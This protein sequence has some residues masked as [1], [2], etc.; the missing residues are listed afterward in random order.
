MRERLT[1]LHTAVLRHPRLVVSLVVLIA[2]LA[3]T[4]S[5]AALDGGAVESLSLGNETNVEPNAINGG[6][7]NP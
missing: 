7:T 6:P 3:L 1:R 5:A 4:G 2:C